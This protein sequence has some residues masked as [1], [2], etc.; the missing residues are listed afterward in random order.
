MGRYEIKGG[1]FN[2]FKIVQTGKNGGSDNNEKYTLRIS[3]IDFFG[4]VTNKLKIGKLKTCRTKINTL[5][6]HVS[7]IS[8]ILCH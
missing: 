5:T 6:F 3:Y 2:S 1:P 7:L 4:Y 8:I